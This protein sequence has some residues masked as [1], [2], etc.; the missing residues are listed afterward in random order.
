M[1]TLRLGMSITNS[2]TENL[3]IEEQI[4]YYAREGF[5][6]FFLS[7]GVTEDFYKIPSWSRLAEK[8]G[9]EFEAVHA[10]SGY[11]NTV[12]ESG[13][14]YT[15]YMRKTKEIID[16]C[17]D[18]C[19]S[20]LVLHSA[21]GRDIKSCEIGL[22][23]FASLEGYAEKAGVHLCYENSD[24]L[25]T[26]SALLEN[27]SPFHG[28]CWDTG[29]NLCYTPNE[30]LGKL[31]GKKLM[32]THLHDNDGKSNLHLLPFD[33]INDWESILKA[34]R[35]A[36]YGGTLNLELSCRGKS[37][38]NL[39]SYADFTHAAYMCAERLRKLI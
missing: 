13:D 20:R 3:S 8:S 30:N 25:S 36:D 7:C 38:Y 35:D 9:I 19:V 27:C 12:W 5:D 34:V 28:F 29:H 31:F 22:E 14:G 32:Y 6:L 37:E 17:S 39:M 11:V 15:L 2:H 10:P 1:K 23:R 16:F 24:N 33:G 26:L 18:G 4:V 21:A